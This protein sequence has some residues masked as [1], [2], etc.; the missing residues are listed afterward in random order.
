M[1][2]GAKEFRCGVEARDLDRMMTAFAAEARLFSPAHWKPLEG[3]E[4]IQALLSV[5][6][7]TFEDFE[8]TDELTSA[9]GTTAL[10]FSARVGKLELQGLDLIRLSSEGLITEF[11]V[12]VRPFSA[13]EAL[14]ARVTEGLM[15]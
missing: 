12:M 14:M 4:V 10:I 1:M 11:T 15:A 5:L 6:L 13:L 2:N 9:E 8:Y 3:R 7:Q